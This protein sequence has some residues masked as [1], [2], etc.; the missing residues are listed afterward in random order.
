MTV[1]FI[2]SSCR[3]RLLSQATPHE[4]KWLRR[5]FYNRTETNATRRAQSGLQGYGSGQPRHRRRPQSSEDAIE[6]AGRTFEARL[7]QSSQSEQQSR[8]IYSRAPLSPSDVGALKETVSSSQQQDGSPATQHSPISNSDGTHVI[9]DQSSST[10]STWGALQRAKEGVRM[11]LPTSSTLGYEGVRPP[12]ETPAIYKSNSRTIQA[13]RTDSLSDRR[14]RPLHERPVLE[15]DASQRKATIDE[16]L[17]SLAL[18]FQHITASSTTSP[19]QA[20]ITRGPTLLP[21]HPLDKLLHLDVSQYLQDIPVFKYD[22]D[23]GLQDA[24]ILLIQRLVPAWC[25]DSGTGLNVPRPTQLHTRMVDMNLKSA[26][27]VEIW[28]ALTWG[29]LREL[30][31]RSLLVNSGDGGKQDRAIL[32]ELVIMWDRFLVRHRYGHMPRTVTPTWPALSRSKRVNEIKEWFSK[33]FATRWGHLFPRFRAG[34]TGGTDTAALLSLGLLRKYKDA[35]Q[36]MPKATGFQDC[37]SR[38]MV[39]STLSQELEKHKSVMLE[40]LGEEALVASLSPQLE[41]VVSNAVTVFEE[42]HTETRVGTHTA[43]KGGKQK[44]SLDDIVESFKKRISRAIADSNPGRVESL[45]TEA[46]SSFSRVQEDNGKLPAALYAHFVFGFAALKRPHRA[47]QVMGGLVQNGITPSLST[48]DSMIRGSGLAR[49]HEAVHDMWEKM[50]QSGVKAD[51]HIWATRIHALAISGHWQSA[52]AAFQ[53]MTAQWISAARAEGSN[54]QVW[55]LPDS[56]DAPKPTARCLNSLVVGLARGL[57]YDQLGEVLRWAKMLDIRPDAYTFNSLFKVAA[58]RQDG[59]LTDSLLKQ[60][61]AL[62]IQPD[63]ATFT[64]MLDSIF[65]EEMQVDEAGQA[66][67]VDNLEEQRQASVASLFRTMQAAGVSATAHTFATLINGL[68]KSTRPNEAAA[69]SIIKYLRAKGLPLS[70]A[71]YTALITHHFESAAPDLGAVERLWNEARAARTLSLDVVFYDRLIEGFARADQV[72]K[73]MTALTQA[74][75]R[76]KVP[77]WIAM[78]EVVSALLRAGERRRA[79]HLVLAVKEEEDSSRDN[80]RARIGQARFWSTVRE[81]GLE[82]APAVEAPPY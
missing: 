64:M 10:P 14:N 78:T 80:L 3:R 18:P 56:T 22:D 13:W 1:P 47:I 38:L 28:D 12:N 39:N 30:S 26:G 34:E 37:V 6:E 71:I 33:D 29:L 62:D 63:I 42:S 76:G 54:G 55:E 73:A 75:K 50:M 11:P 59:A 66:A 70:S 51:A 23:S 58:L 7:Q 9:R 36:G 44:T 40:K 27:G 61:Q 53:Q 82:G 52:M 72:G 8:K 74:G 35:G 48:W 49:D 4:T 21:V 81:G 60:M 68:L 24:C 15:N 32:T 41:W 77:G 43:G 46:Q 57:K 2:C 65:Q 45:F 69:Y 31:K 67:D 19:I 16:E 20:P 17:M 79:Q 5:A 25:N